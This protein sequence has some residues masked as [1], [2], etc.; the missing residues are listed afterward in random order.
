MAWVVTAVVAAFEVTTVATVL[1]AISAVGMATTVVGAVTG[2]KNL[3]KIGGEI[4]MVGGI[5][6]LVNAGIGALGAA[7]A[8]VAAGQIATDVAS[9]TAGDAVADAAGDAVSNVATDGLVADSV[10]GLAGTVS[11]ASTMAGGTPAWTSAGTG[12]GGGFGL[13]SDVAGSDWIGSQQNSMGMSTDITGAVNPPNNFMQPVSQTVPMQGYATNAVENS[14]PTTGFDTRYDTGIVFNPD[15]SIDTTTGNKFAV[16]AEDVGAGLDKEGIVPAND[17]GKFMGS[18][19]SSSSASS[20]F[21]DKLGSKWDSLTDAQK[22][23]FTKTGLALPFN[24]LNQRNQQAALELQRQ[25]QAQTSYGSDVPRFGIIN[26]VRR[27]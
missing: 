17:L 23:E 9:Q 13:S 26:S 18:S 6:S 10:P 24:I 2:N 21:L 7:G 25:K 16:A 8:D 27:T 20:S 4:S 1:T 12:S 19:T 15:N 3:M 11:D 5:G 22:L 14:I